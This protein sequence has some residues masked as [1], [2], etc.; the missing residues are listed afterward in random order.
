MYTPCPLER[1][2]KG[3]REG[4][5]PELE[6][7]AWPSHPFQT[8][9]QCPW[10][11]LL[12]S[13]SMRLRPGGAPHPHALQDRLYG[14]SVSSARKGSAYQPIYTPHLNLIAPSISSDWKSQGF[15]DH[16]HPL[17]PQPPATQ[18]NVSQGDSL[19]FPAGSVPALWVGSTLLPHLRHLLFPHQLIFL[20]MCS[21][22]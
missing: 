11:R 8:Q 20:S 16:Y 19:P 18:K 1:T 12:R 22:L 5:D 2:G 7:S 3:G 13:C 9:A 6:P 14:V 4:E 17:L 10:W 21:L 15:R